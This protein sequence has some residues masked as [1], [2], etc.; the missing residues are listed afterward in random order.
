MDVAA[1]EDG[2]VP[3]ILEGLEA[4]LLDQGLAQFGQEGRKRSARTR[5]QALRA[6][7]GHPW[8]WHQGRAVAM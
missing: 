4:A 8:G 2:A 7:H 5:A 6:A 1:A 3:L